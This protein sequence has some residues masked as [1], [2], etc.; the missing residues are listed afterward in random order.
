MIQ[1]IALTVGLFAAFTSVA[2]ARIVEGPSMQP[3]LYAGERLLIDKVSYLRV[4]STPLEGLAGGNREFLLAGPQRGDVVILRPQTPIRSSQGDS[5][6]FPFIAGEEMLV[7]RLIGLPGDSI[8]IRDGR[9][10]VNDVP[11]NEPYV[12]YAASYTYPAN[13]QPAVVPTGQYFVLGDNR[14][15]SNDSHLGWFVPARDLVGRALLAFWPPTSW[16][17]LGSAA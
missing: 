14:P 13:G 11:L 6:V 9:V 16:G 15:N 8:L 12:R 5:P 10:L 4:D 1:T 7:K 2:E 17:V 3:T